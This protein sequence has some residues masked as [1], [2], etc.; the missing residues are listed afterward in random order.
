MSKTDLIKYLASLRGA[1]GS[2]AA[3]MPG[4]AKLMREAGLEPADYG[5][6]VEGEDQIPQ[7]NSNILICSST[8]PGGRA[9][10]ELPSP[11]TEGKCH[12]CGLPVWY[13]TENYERIKPTPLTLCN[14][15]AEL[16]M[17]ADIH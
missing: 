15:C 11:P 16:M 13:L 14:K 4:A 7:S 8:K 2:F 1:K 10:T 12:H 6:L 3:V 9:L 17:G 5:I